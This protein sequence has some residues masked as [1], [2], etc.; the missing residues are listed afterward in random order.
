MPGTIQ[1]IIA[2]VLPLTANGSLDL[3]KEPPF[4]VLTPGWAAIA[5]LDLE[6]DV[7]HIQR[8]L[9]FMAASP[10]EASPVIIGSKGRWITG[11]AHCLGVEHAHRGRRYTLALAKYHWSTP[12]RLS[13]VARRRKAA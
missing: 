1:V 2:G 5:E 10:G 8:V 4:R 6:R 7:P 13:D 11:D 12:C 9:D 3:R